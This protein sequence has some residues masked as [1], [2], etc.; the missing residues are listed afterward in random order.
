MSLGGKTEEQS[1]ERWSE[2]TQQAITKEI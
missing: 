2:W 1:S